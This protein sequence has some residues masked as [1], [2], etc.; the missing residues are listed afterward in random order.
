MN[1]APRTVDNY[2]QSLFDKLE[3]KS[4]VGLVLFALRNGIVKL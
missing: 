3:L 4:R 1:I 2:R